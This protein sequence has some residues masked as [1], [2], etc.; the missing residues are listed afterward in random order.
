[1]PETITRARLAEAI[2]R[3]VGL[4]RGHAASFVDAM[5]RE[6][7]QSL[8]KGETVKLCGF[9]TISVRTKGRRIGRNPKTCEE[10]PIKERRIIVFRASSLF[11]D[12]IN[13][14]IA[15]RS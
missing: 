2:H 6:I 15:S 3:E 14:C 5:L 4:S 12:S 1:M 10:F 13:A 9:G 11:K 7:I 8:E